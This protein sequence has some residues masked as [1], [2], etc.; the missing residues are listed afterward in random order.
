MGICFCFCCH[1]SNHPRMTSLYLKR[2]LDQARR[3]EVN[4]ITRYIA[5]LTVQPEKNTAITQTWLKAVHAKKDSCSRAFCIKVIEEKRKKKRQ[6]NARETIESVGRRIPYNIIRLIDENGTD[7]G[8]M[9]RGNVLRIMDERGMNL[10]LLSDK[11][12]P[13][14][15]QLMTGKQIYEERLKTRDE[16]ASSK[17]GSVQEKRIKMSTVTE[18]HDFSTKIKQIQEWIDKKYHV[19]IVLYQKPISDGPE[20]MLTFFDQILDTMREK[21]TYHSMPSVTGEGRSTCVLRQLSKKEIQ[22]LKLAEKNKDTQ[23]E[24]GSNITDSDVT[25]Q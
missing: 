17:T 21:A 13:P 6:S 4:Y 7:K 11:T 16:K 10:I 20:K 8:E 25:K 9:H 18:Q 23:K 15:Y 1:F 19:K 3:K 12:D 2:L 14:K 24:N 5:S 22:K